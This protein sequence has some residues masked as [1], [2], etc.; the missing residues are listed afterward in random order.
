MPLPLP[1]I[2]TLCVALLGVTAPLVA[3]HG[4]TVR[5]VPAAF[6]L[7]SGDVPVD[8]GT[9]YVPANRSRASSG[10]LSLRFVRFRSTGAAPAPAIV[11][12]A[13]GPGDAGIRA[14]HGIPAEFLDTLRTHGDVI[15][16]DQRGTGLSE[17]LGLHC[18]VNAWLPL[19]LPGSDSLY[20]PIFRERVAGCLEDVRARG[21]D[22]AGL[23]TRESADDLALLDQV[24]GSPGLVLFGGSYGTHLAITTARRHPEIVRGLI[25]AGVEGPDQ[26]FKLPLSADRALARYDSAHAEAG[27]RA[28]ARAV[29]DTLALRPVPV[30]VNGDTVT[31]GPWD[32]RRMVADAVGSAR[33]LDTLAESLARMLRGEY[34]DLARHAFRFRRNP[35][36]DLLNI[37]MDC[38]SGASPGRLEA[39][40]EQAEVH[41]REYDRLSEAPRLH[42]RRTS[43]PRQYLPPAAEIRGPR[44]ADQR[45]ARRADAAGERDG[46][47]GGIAARPTA[48]N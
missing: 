40:R 41:R 25:L 22:V 27:L 39:I 24:L 19:D 21:V 3:Q 5:L 35:R 45:E 23:T 15:A 34:T 8:E 42:R 16:L 30:A 18:T 4:D 26:T 46:T 7:R 13:G 43:P 29:L 9:L 33:A 20:A 1:P 6:R 10:T 14:F 36:T 28:G 11:F 48:G 37:A 44:P 2:A 31:V 38:A 17:P 12:L 47:G 32:L